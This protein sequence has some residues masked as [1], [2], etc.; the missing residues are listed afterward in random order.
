MKTCAGKSDPAASP[1]IVG[2]GAN[3]HDT[4]VT[5]PHYP[6]EDTKLR[7]DN[8][9]ECGGGPCGTGLV[10]AAKL[11]ARCAYIGVL[12]DDSSGRF[13]VEDMRRFNVLDAFVDVKSG[14]SAFSSYI[15]LSGETA[16]RTC[17]FNK[18]NLPPLELSEEQMMAVKSA[19][20]LMIDG[21]ELEAAIEAAKAAKESGTLVLYDAG[22]LYDGVDRLLPYAD[23]LIPSEEFAKGHTGEDSAESA[24]RALYEKYKPKMV[25]VTCGRDGG[26]LYCGGEPIVRYP[27][28]KVEAV[29]SNGAG[30]VFHGAFAF[31]LTR[32]MTYENACIFSSA[33][34]ALKCTHIGARDGVPQL[35]EVIKFLKE[36]GYD[37]FEKNME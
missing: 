7:A 21:N 12:S 2:I 11:G 24:A 32:G 3:V 8:V 22:G 31:A 16:S 33:V 35:D 19:K 29:D 9:V 26:V 30:D 6:T 13:L 17:V 27:A 28:F 34:S 1:E 37:E 25:A 18:G 23:I 20:L 10:A 4:L 36:R 5:V 14:Y 15:W